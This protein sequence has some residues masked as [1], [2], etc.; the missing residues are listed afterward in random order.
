MF[1]IYLYTNFYR[2]CSHGSLVI[3]IRLEAKHVLLFHILWI[4]YPNQS[5]I[6]Y[7][8]SVSTQNLRILH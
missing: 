1:M 5:C 3:T 7:W 4:D 6:L 2:P 8:R